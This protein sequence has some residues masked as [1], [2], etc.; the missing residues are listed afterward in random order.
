MQILLNVLGA[1]AC[2]VLVLL[3]RLLVDTLI[4]EAKI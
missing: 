4:G 3:Q 2:V 1:C